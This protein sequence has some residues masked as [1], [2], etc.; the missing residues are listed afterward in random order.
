M[1][2][3]SA[4]KTTP[5]KRKG[6]LDA[7]ESLFSRGNVSYVDEKYAEAEKFFTQ[8]LEIDNS[9]PNYYLHRA[10]T[11]IKLRNYKKAL[12]DSEQA[13]QVFPGS[14]TGRLRK[15]IALFHLNRFKDAKDVFEEAQRL[16][17]KNCGLWIRKCAAELNGGKVPGEIKQVASPQQRENKAATVAKLVASS[18]SSSSTNT[19]SSLKSTPVRVTKSKKTSQSYP[20]PSS[21]SNPTKYRQGWYQ[22]VSTVCVTLYARGLKTD[23]VKI[24]FEPK[25][26]VVVIRESP[27]TTPWTRKLDLFSDID[28]QKSNYRLTPF[29]LEINLHKGI[30]LDWPALEARTSS[31]IKQLTSSSKIKKSPYTS[32]TDWNAVE[33]KIE[34]E[35]EE[36]KPQGEAALQALFQ[37]IYKNADDNT[38]RAMN[39]SY[40]TSNGTV[41][42]TNWGEVA[43]KDYEKTRQAPKGQEIVDYEI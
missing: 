21:S 20:P 3:G 9:N 14:T 42:S 28:T 25:S 38:K 27:G 43:K 8:A 23:Q 6:D 19:Q 5:Q 13:V 35:L 22:N 41:L 12:A 32:G 26:V 29:K 33:K 31:A 18:S 4:S 24:S 11:N 15:G 7:A 2:S 16:G 1:R 10:A 30:A 37:N 34:K 40:Q 17:H 39:K 36:D